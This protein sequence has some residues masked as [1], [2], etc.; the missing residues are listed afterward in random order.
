MADQLTEEQREQVSEQLME[1]FKFLDKDGDGFLSPQELR[2][3]FTKPGE[4]ISPQ[5][6]EMINEADVDGDGQVD[7]EEFVKMAMTMMASQ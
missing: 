6:N 5:L 7:Y 2:K 1:T 3:G 4:Y